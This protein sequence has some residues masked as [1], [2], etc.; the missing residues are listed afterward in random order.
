MKKSKYDDYPEALQ[1]EKR[2]VRSDKYQF[3]IAE[4]TSGLIIDNDIMYIEYETSHEPDELKELHEQLK[5]RQWELI[6]EH[7]TEHQLNVCVLIGKGYTQAETAEIMGVQQSTITKAII[8]N[9]TYKRNNINYNGEKFG[10]VAK[11]MKKIAKEDRIYQ[12]ILTKIREL[13][14]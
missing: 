6:R 8:G 11:K 10:G 2:P 4:I 5:R 9:A 7:S 3:K 13:T 1:L 14:E 12:D